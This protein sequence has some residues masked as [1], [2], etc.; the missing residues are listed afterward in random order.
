MKQYV[1]LTCHMRLSLFVLTGKK[2]VERLYNIMMSYD[3]T[4]NEW[5]RYEF[6]DHNVRRTTDSN[7]IR[8][9]IAQQ[10]N[11]GCH[12]DVQVSSLCDFAS[13]HSLLSLFLFISTNSS[14][15]RST[16]KSILVILSRVFRVASV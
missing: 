9:R 5:K 1:F 10:L 6:F 3:Y 2:D 12:S 16:R 4:G 15:L 8:Q 13:Y 11:M 7:I 14:V